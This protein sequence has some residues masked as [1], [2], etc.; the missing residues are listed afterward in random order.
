MYRKK[1]RRNLWRKEKGNQG[2]KEDSYTGLKV[3]EEFEY[4]SRNIDY[5]TT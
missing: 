1:N 5:D 3:L 4:F 2:K